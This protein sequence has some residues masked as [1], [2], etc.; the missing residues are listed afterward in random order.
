[1][2]PTDGPRTYV[3]RLCGGVRWGSWSERSR[4][5][6]PGSSCRVRQR[7]EFEAA[8]LLLALGRPGKPPA[9]RALADDELAPQVFPVAV[10][11]LQQAA[12]D[13]TLLWSRSGSHVNPSRS[14]WLVEIARWRLAIARWRSGCLHTVRAITL[15]SSD[16]WWKTALHRAI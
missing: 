1:M 7:W 5:W 10:R 4:V 6:K 9:R 15:N 3:K 11:A 16:W 8:Q 2:D 13:D 12:R 14:G